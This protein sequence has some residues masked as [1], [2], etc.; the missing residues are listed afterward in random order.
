MAGAVALNVYFPHPLALSLLVLVAIN[1][2]KT[3]FGIN[4]FY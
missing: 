3:I 2:V 1:L 4:I